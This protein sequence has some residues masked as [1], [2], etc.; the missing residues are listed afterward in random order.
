METGQ[1]R[2]ILNVL[3]NVKHFLIEKAISVT[4]NP[5][6]KYTGKRL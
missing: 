3:T 4:K 1:K 2:V 6:Y 5:L